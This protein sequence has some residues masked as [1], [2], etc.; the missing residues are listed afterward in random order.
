MRLMTYFTN[1]KKNIYIF[2]I[3]LFLVTV[4][5]LPLPLLSKYLV[6]DVIATKNLT[7]LSILIIIFLIIILLQIVFN[8]INTKYFAS[9]SQTIIKDIRYRIYSSI[10]SDHSSDKVESGKIQT[11]LLNDSEQFVNNELEILSTILQKLILVFGYFI[12]SMSLSPLLTLIC[13]SLIPIY[14][15]W[16]IWSSNHLKENIL[17]AQNTKDAFLEIYKKDFSNRYIIKLFNF[18]FYSQKRINT[19]LNIHKSATEKVLVRQN[20]IY[21]ISSVISSLAIY[22]PLFFGVYLVITNRLTLGTLMAFQSYSAL[23]FP[24]LADLLSLIGTNKINDV[25]FDRLLPYLEKKQ[26]DRRPSNRNLVE[27]RFL[28]EVLDFEIKDKLDF[29]LFSSKLE[30]KKGAWIDLVGINGSGK[31]VFLKCLSKQIETYNG[32]IRI[33]GVNLKN[34]CVEN[35][36]KNV[37]YV[38]SNQ[39]FI[40]DTIQDELSS[41][42]IVYLKKLFEIVLLNKKIEHLPKGYSTTL[43]ELECLLSTGELQKFR[44]ARALSK[45]P[46]VLLLDEI[47]SNI[48]L[49]TR[50]NIINNIKKNYPKLTVISVDHI[51]NQDN[52]CKLLINKNHLHWEGSHEQR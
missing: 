8:F 40:S 24:A 39:G 45:A 2:L 12:I 9:L 32:I 46:K 25:Y 43:E 20:L 31:T 47:L 52:N 4:L 30:I 28:I 7:T 16:V 5:A 11:L 19:A 1:I 13:I 44:I 3:T 6:D 18:V 23:L 26:E 51:S 35:L 29:F 27:P 38:S 50:K 37:V 33:D 15:F 14:T 17:I 41:E 22:S 34:I 36:A 21:V 42:N 10:I 49:E 48:D